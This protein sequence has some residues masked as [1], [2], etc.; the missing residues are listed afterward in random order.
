[1]VKSTYTIYDT[2]SKVF[3]WPFTAHNDQDAIRSFSNSITK[4]IPDRAIE[5]VL[6]KN[7]EYDDSTGIFTSFEPVPVFR[8]SEIDNNNNLR[9]VSNA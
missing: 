3:N 1:M 7:G 8:G 9:D 6:Y 4:E 5:F 2:I